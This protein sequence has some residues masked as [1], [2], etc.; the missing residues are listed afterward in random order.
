M[1]LGVLA[2]IM[3][4][5]FIASP[6]LILA[7]TDVQIV[8]AIFSALLGTVFLGITFSGYLFRY[9]SQPK[10]LLALVATLSFFFPLAWHTQ[11]A[12]ISYLVGVVMAGTLLVSE[13]LRKNVT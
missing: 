4:F 3:P 6:A 12:W 9:L 1:R 7:G 13:W 5:L 8:V 11:L 10:R 2:Y